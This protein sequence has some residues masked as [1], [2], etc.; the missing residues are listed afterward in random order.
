M[1]VRILSFITEIFELSKTAIAQLNIKVSF[2]SR[3]CK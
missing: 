3:L 1:K 2:E